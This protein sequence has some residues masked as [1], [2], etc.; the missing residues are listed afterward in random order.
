M[1]DGDLNQFQI[2]LALEQAEWRGG[3]TKELENMNETL[4]KIE[5]KLAKLSATQTNIRIKTYGIATSLS[6][7]IVLLMKLV[8][9]I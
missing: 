5:D 9:H 7:I 6:I 1:P 4:E 2:E 3:V 8:F